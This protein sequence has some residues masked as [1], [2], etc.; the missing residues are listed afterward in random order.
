MYRDLQQYWMRRPA[1]EEEA[2]FVINIAP[3]IRER[4][5]AA[6]RVRF[7]PEHLNEGIRE[8]QRRDF[9]ELVEAARQYRDILSTVASLGASLDASRISRR[10]L[11]VAGASLIVALVTVLGSKFGDNSVFHKL[12]DL[13]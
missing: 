3:Y 9:E 2:E 11:F 13:F 7:E 5:A 1:F 10:A 6:G 4:Q 12:L 8:Q